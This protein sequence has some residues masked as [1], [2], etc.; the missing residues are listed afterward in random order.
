MNYAAFAIASGKA[1]QATSD[2]KDKV[3]QML[4]DSPEEQE[5]ADALNQLLSSL[6]SLNPGAAEN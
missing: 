4:G 5:A 1:V 3:N 6:E 2:L